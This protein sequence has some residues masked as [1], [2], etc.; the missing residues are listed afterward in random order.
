VPPS[1]PLQIAALKPVSCGSVVWSSRGGLRVT[2]IVKATFGMVHESSAR[3]VAPLPIRTEDRAWEGDP[4]RSLHEA[5]ETA[6]HLAQ[7]GIILQGVA[8]APSGTTVPAMSA[9]LAV[10]RDASRP[11]LDKT[12][13]VFGDRG[14]TGGAPAPFRSM[15]VVYERAFGGADVAENPV[16][17]GSPP[18]ANRM[19]NV[20]DPADLRRP[21]G[22][23]PIARRWHAR[24][25]K[26]HGVAREALE[27]EGTLEIPDGFDWSYFQA[28]PAD[29]QV[30]F[31]QG[32]EWILLDGLHADTPRVQTRLP[33]VKGRARWQLP[34]PRGPRPL[35]PI[36]LV[37]DTLVIDAE[38]KLCSLIWRGSFALHSLDALPHVRV[39][40]G[41]E[42]PAYPITWPADP[43]PSSPEL[44]GGT[45]EAPSPFA[46]I[47]DMDSTTLERPSPLRDTDQPPRS[48]RGRESGPV[49][50]LP[51]IKG[52]SAPIF[53]HEPRPPE[54]PAPKG[55]GDT[56]ADVLSPFASALP[57][58]PASPP[59]AAPSSVRFAAPPADPPPP[60]RA[61]PPA[62]A[63]DDADSNTMMLS[64]EEIRARS[65]PVAP[66]DLAE[67]GAPAPPSGRSIPGAPWS[68][69]PANPALGEDFE[70]EGTFVGA[71]AIDPPPPPLV[72]PAME[73]PRGGQPP[74]MG[75]RAAPSPGLREPDAAVEAAP[76]SIEAPVTIA[77][78]ATEPP[79]AWTPTPNAEPPSMAQDAAAAPEF[80]PSF[81]P[82][83]QERSLRQTVLERLARRAPLADLP[84]AGADLGGIDLSGAVLHELNLKGTNLRGAKLENAR[85]AEAQL[86]EA[87]LT[88]AV[89]SGADL[90]RADLSRATLTG[91]KLDGARVSDTNFSSARGS[92]ASF[93]GASGQRPIFT[94]GT[95][96]GALFD[97]LDA[98]L[99]D[100]TGA[101]LAT[102]RFEGAA[103]QDAR[104]DDARGDGAVFDGAKL[105]Q[106]RFQSASFVG[107][108]FRAIDAP[109]SLWE[110]ATL[111]QAGFEGARLRGASFSR[112][113]CT[114]ARFAGADLGGVNL[115]RLTADRTDFRKASLEGAD[116]R[117]GHLEEAVFDEANLKKAQ[118]SKAVFSNGSFVGADLSAAVM[119]EAKLGRANL[120]GVVFD[121]TDL[122]DADL[123]GANL[124]GTDRQK[125]KL[126]GANLKDVVDGEP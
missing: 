75:T 106:A 23:G 25:S 99:A 5:A 39:Y 86:V 41:V 48:S 32:D 35:E 63:R 34:G 20:V 60:S 83:T 109:G 79:P 101:S 95:W 9:R 50:A 76:S 103:L 13:F 98:R 80:L 96:D 90:T 49:S 114:E 38:R 82:E 18:H 42:L 77:S 52:A 65:R 72:L 88:E 12:L 91:A 105:G 116:L 36:E 118:A 57:F 84:L 17:V 117:Q 46:G 123:E 78:A 125:A 15:P 6:P 59:D 33:A 85:L 93:S 124:H 43:P 126:G 22:F 53:F 37:A 4:S 40:A 14:A 31:L 55:Q 44:V 68:A 81:D 94:R 45:L 66:F 87:D 112:A 111:S 56:T 29:Q 11:L 54:A 1:W 100:F 121:A 73:E 24:A 71:H 61:H 27:R 19:P 58:K 69:V 51:F 122:R 110:K 119:R 107:A 67:P 120:S 108:S 97:Q 64:I 8:H 113:T 92:Q 89:L 21:A 102:A 7:A 28:A 10:F 104:F 16:G 70:D 30:P 2:V 115:Q 26:L 62:P 47:G 74:I 3:L